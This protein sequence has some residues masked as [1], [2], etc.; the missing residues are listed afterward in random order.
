VTRA[1]LAGLV[2][3]AAVL[4]G[5]GLGAGDDQGGGAELRVT[6]DFGQKEL[7]SADRPSVKEGDTVMRF[8]QSER[9]V[10]LRYGGGFVQSIDGLSGQGAGG[11]RDWFYWVNGQEGSVGAADRKLHPGDVVQ[12]DY[13][14]WIA[15]MT[16]PGIVGAYPEPFLHGIDGK[17]QPVRLE[18]SDPEGDACGDVRDRLKKDGVVASSGSPGTPGRG[19]VARLFVGPWGDLRQIRSLLTLEKGP[20]A[21]GVFARFGADGARLDLLDARGRVARSGGPG[22]GLVAATRVGQDEGISFVVT[23]VDGPGVTAAAG[24]LDRKTL[25]NA[26]AVAVTGGRV[27]RL[28]VQPGAGD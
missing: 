20:S 15:T 13:R 10:A 12:W 1:R 17:K 5:C 14:D 19:Q 6:R 9:K 11:R 22:T 25:R 7:A 26:F 18:C 2:A 21:S 24:A 8:L 28:P 4:A 3:V 16:I 23:G 27:T